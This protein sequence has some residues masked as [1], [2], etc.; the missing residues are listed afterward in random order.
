[1]RPW[2]YRAEVADAGVI[3]EYAQYVAIHPFQRILD[4]TEPVPPFEDDR[5]SRQGRR[6]RRRRVD[7]GGGG[8]R[9]IGD[10]GGGGGGG[11]LGGRGLRI[12]RGGIPLQLRQGLAIAASGEREEGGAG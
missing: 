8:G 11:G 5:A 1:M 3:D 9:G 10:G 2:P 6:R 4:P 12:G 7:G